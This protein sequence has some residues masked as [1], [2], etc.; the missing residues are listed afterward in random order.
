MLTDLQIER[1]ARHVLLREVGGVG[2]ER[3]LAA[4][5][6]VAGLGPAGAWATAYLALA[7]V[8][9]LELWD[10]AAVGEEDLAPLLGPAA[11]G[12]RR[13]EAMVAAVAAYN[14][15][16]VATAA[17]PSSSADVMVLADLA[18][19]ATG[20]GAAGEELQPTLPPGGFTM[21]AFAAGER[22]IAGMLETDGP[23][24]SCVVRTLGTADRPTPIAALAAGSLVAM[25]VLTGISTGVGLAGGFLLSDGAGLRRVEPGAIGCRHRPRSPTRWP[26]FARRA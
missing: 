18:L 12:R 1:Y 8:G 4:R 10:A 2:Q 15:D 22:A 16:V 7:G 24:A 11:L 14:P 21:A 17:R 20:E 19:A 26:V 9:R 23:C 6:A 25:A 13:D 5:V 3:L